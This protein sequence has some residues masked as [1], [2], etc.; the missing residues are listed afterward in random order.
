MNKFLVE[1]VEA[2]IGQTVWFLSSGGLISGELHDI[3]KGSRSIGV[4]KA[5]HHFGKQRLSLG[6]INIDANQVSAWGL[7]E[8][9]LE[10]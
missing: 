7:D 6:D 9:T 4:I 5:F 8:P 3:D 1:F 2:N 10:A